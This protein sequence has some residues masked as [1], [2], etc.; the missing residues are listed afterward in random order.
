MLSVTAPAW[1]GSSNGHRTSP[2]LHIV[3]Y[4]T[5]EHDNRGSALLGS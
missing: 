1:L 4:A 3:A 5:P 2:A